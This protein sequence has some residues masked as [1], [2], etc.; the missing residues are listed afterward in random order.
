VLVSGKKVA[1]LGQNSRSE[2]FE[3][4]VSTTI[5]LSDDLEDQ[6]AVGSVVLSPS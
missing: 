6:G 5:L 2:F 1:M 3:K 4:V